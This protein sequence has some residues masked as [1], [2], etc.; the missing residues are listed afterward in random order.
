[1]ATATT[2]SYLVADFFI[3]FDEFR[4]IV[5]AMIGRRHYEL[6]GYDYQVA[7]RRKVMNRVLQTQEEGA[8]AVERRF[9][10]YLPREATE[11]DPLETLA[12]YVARLTPPSNWNPIRW[13][14]HTDTYFASNFLNRTIIIVW[15]RAR[16]SH[17]RADIYHPNFTSEVFF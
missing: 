8:T 1:M 17:H 13:A 10:S 9:A 14:Q 2:G 16:Q 12:E 6:L 15:K 11:D 4:A 3:D 7:L 5:S